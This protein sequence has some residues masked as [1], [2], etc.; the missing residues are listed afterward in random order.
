MKVR[1][2]MSNTNMAAIKQALKAEVHEA[3]PFISDRLRLY[4][5]VDE[6]VQ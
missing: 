6:L 4:D 2:S 5:Y 1:I 3:I